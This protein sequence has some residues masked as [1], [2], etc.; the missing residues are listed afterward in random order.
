[1]RTVLRFALPLLGLGV[2]A[3]FATAS[4]ATPEESARADALFKEG[5]R[6][7]DGG[8]TAKAC[9]KFADS[10]KLDPALGTLQNLALCHEKEGRLAEAYGELTELLAKAQAAGKTQR[11]DVAREHLSSLDTKVPRVVLS[12][13]EGVQVSGV[14]ID[15]AARDWRAPIV[16]DPGHHAITAHAEGRPDAHV[17]YDA[18]TGGAQTVPVVFT[19]GGSATPPPAPAPAPTA[20]SSALSSQ[21]SASG[22]SPSGPSKVVVFGL[23]GVGVAGIAV[24]SVFGVLTFSQKSAGDSHCA[25][26][27]CDASGL[28]S[29]NNAH[30]SATVS[31]IGFAVGLAALAVDAVVILTSHKGKAGAP[32]SGAMQGVLAVSF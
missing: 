28:A 32:A 7:F 6:L 10:Y 19:G 15:G 4:A 30:T 12:F 27:Y 9:A 29:Q 25:G 18:N 8:Q 11:A 24:G 1:M 22:P 26:M 16:L 2:P 31:T 17:E 23:A 14:E 3:F 5:L 21:S 13:G 20:P